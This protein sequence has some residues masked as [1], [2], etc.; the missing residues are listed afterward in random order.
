MI[1]LVGVYQATLRPLLGR[2][3]R[4][5][6]TCSDY[7]RIALRRRGTLG[8]LWLTMKRIGRCHP[9]GGSGYDPVPDES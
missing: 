2:H 7:A 5:Q 3:C 1:D 8:G 4:F 6:P 9:L